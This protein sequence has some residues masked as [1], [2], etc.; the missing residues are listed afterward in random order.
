MTPIARIERWVFIYL[1]IE[2]HV[3]PRIAGSSMDTRGVFKLYPHDAG[4]IVNSAYIKDRVTG[5]RC[6]NEKNNHSRT[7][8]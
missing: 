4:K 5:R 3:L 6:E 8:S 7:A 2:I 1:K